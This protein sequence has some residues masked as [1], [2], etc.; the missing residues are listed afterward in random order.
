[1]TIRLNLSTKDT[2]QYNN[3]EQEPKYITIWFIEANSG[4]LVSTFDLNGPLL[5]LFVKAV[6]V[7]VGFYFILVHWFIEAHTRWLLF[8]I[9]LEYYILRTEL[10]L[11]HNYEH[12]C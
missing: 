7:Y 3:E 6:I 4:I 10:Y 8:K 1:M 12:Y 11:Q 9:L 2:S 5:L